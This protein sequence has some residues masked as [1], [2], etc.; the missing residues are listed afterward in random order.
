[1]ELN[2]A[3]E[4]LRGHNFIAEDFKNDAKAYKA[5][6]KTFKKASKM[7]DKYHQRGKSVDLGYGLTMEIRG[8]NQGSRWDADDIALYRKTKDGRERIGYWAVNNYDTTKDLQRAI[9]KVLNTYAEKLHDDEAYDELMDN[10]NEI[11]SKIDLDDYK[12]FQDKTT[13]RNRRVSDVYD[14]IHSQDNKLVAAAKDSW[15]KEHPIQEGDAV[16]LYNPNGKNKTGKVIAIAT[17]KNSGKTVYKVIFDGNARPSLVAADNPKLHK[18]E[19]WQTKGWKDLE[20]FGK[21]SNKVS[22]AT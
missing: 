12:K 10:A 4:I 7:Y 6:Q 18:A 21:R 5:Y 13:K 3:L 15:E 16:Y 19:N 17:E 14:A 22:S 9:R 2:E 20:N 8:E 1:M 11:L